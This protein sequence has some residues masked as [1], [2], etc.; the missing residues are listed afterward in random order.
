MRT[1]PGTGELRAL[2]YLDEVMGLAPPVGN[3]PPKKPILTLLKQ[4]RAFGV[5]LVLSTQ[6]PVDLD[7]KAISNAGTWLIGRLQTDQDKNRLVD[8]LRSA[9]GGVDIATV[10]Q[11]IS[12][13]G[14]RQFMLRT[15]KSSSLPL[16]TSRW[17]MSYLAGPLTREQ[18]STLMDPRREA[19][20]GAAAA[21]SAATRG[22]DAV[23]A[24][25]TPPSR[26]TEAAALADD[27]STVPP[28][29]PDGIVPLTVRPSAPWL[30]QL[31]LDPDSHRLEPALA[32]RVTLL[33]DDTKADLR[34]SEEWEAIIPLTGRSAD[35]A[36]A[37]EVDFDD[38]DFTA[39]DPD[40]VGLRP[41]RV[42]HHHRGAP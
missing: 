2:V 7:Y 12:G 30:D 39:R 14:K 10:E 37:V 26:A 36:E 19:I 38:R 25:G 9:D 4:A 42:R 31:G 3:P 35:V 27:E 16:L 11:T 8:G 40:G 29:L 32:A 21:N 20:I 17:A 28:S 23:A 24:A 6:N 1:Q 22:S 18:I 13:L 33:F 5:G 15:T 41:A 34:H